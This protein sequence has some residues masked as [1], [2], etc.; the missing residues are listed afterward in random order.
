MRSTLRAP[1]RTAGP[2]DRRPPRRALPATTRPLARSTTR[3]GC[4]PS[5]LCPRGHPAATA[6]RSARC[7][8]CTSHRPAL[9]CPAAPTRG[10]G[11]KKHSEIWSQ[12]QTAKDAGAKA[13]AVSW[14]PSVQGCSEGSPGSVS[15]RDGDD[16]RMIDAEVNVATPDVLTCSRSSVGVF[17][18]EY[19]SVVSVMYDDTT[20]RKQ[21]HQIFT[22]CHLLSFRDGANSHPIRRC[23]H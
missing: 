7:K 10:A 1:S 22:S 21:T 16:E 19:I 6:A 9:A 14:S 23:C 12:T 8:E 20:V 3:S 2:G 5:C 4:L 18:R 13:R 11:L 17:H 15:I